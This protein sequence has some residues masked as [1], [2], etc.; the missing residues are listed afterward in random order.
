MVAAAR[1]DRDAVNRQNDHL[2]SQLQDTEVLLASHQEQLAQLKD[3]M[4]QLTVE[5]EEAELSR[6]QTPALMSMKSRDS[7]T[8]DFDSLSSTLTMEDLPPLPATSLPNIV[9]PVLRYDIP[10]YSDFIEIL[11]AAK[12]ARLTPPQRS[13]GGS[14]SSIQVMGMSVP[15]PPQ[16]AG[17]SASFFGKRKPAVN[18]G[19]ASVGHSPS[20][21]AGD[22]QLIWQSLRETKFYKRVL[23]EDIEPTLRLENSPGLSWLARRS[24][25][26]AI[27][28]GSLVIDPIPTPS[29]A[30]GGSNTVGVMFPCSMCGESR[31]G[32]EHARTHRMRINENQGAQRYPLCG[33]CVNRLRCVCDF[34]VFLRAIREGIW[35]CDTQEEMQHA[36]EESVKLRER[37]F[38]ARIGGGMVPAAYGR[39]ERASRRSSAAHYRPDTPSRMLGKASS[40]RNSLEISRRRNTG[41]SFSTNTDQKPTHPSPLVIESSSENLEVFDDASSLSG[42]DVSDA[43]AFRPASTAE[44]PS[45]PKAKDELKVDDTVETDSISSKTTA[46]P[47][48]DSEA[49]SPTTTLQGPMTIPIPTP[50]ALATTGER[51]RTPTQTIPG[52]W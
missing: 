5:K 3:V 23:V 28:E 48:I 42:S 9:L 24:V 45:L 37:M 1:R 36:W 6:P 50:T 20:N 32:D 34:M 13:S 30:K 33:Y 22:A 49:I 52:G 11:T 4:Q 43:K 12:T 27:T 26:T 17:L 35:K 2:K 51:P 40:M 10:A 38:W 21:S 47:S 46:A 7:L 41:E 29:A 16:S 19:S 25:Q 44:A 8:V 14:F 18:S 31:S 39:A 15:S